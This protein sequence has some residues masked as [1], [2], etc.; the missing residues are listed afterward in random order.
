MSIR[1]LQRVQDHFLTVK[2]KDSAAC[3]MPT[4]PLTTHILNTA[5][6][7]PAASVAISI[8]RL[9]SQGWTE[10]AKG[11]TNS[12]GRCPGLFTPQTFSA[13]TYKMQFETGDYWQSLQQSSVYPYVQ[14]VFNISDVSQKYHIA[15]LLSPFSYTTYRGS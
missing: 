6:G 12:D 8:S 3:S 1:R 7:V 14:I 15:L 10:V 2:G 5:Q 9:E 11:I 13:G 4:S